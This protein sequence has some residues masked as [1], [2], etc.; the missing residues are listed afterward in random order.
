MLNNQKNITPL[1]EGFSNLKF[2]YSINLQTVT[3]PE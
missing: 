3:V 1:Q 2:S